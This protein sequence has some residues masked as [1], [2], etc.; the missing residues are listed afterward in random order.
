[1]ELMVVSVEKFKKFRYWGGCSGGFVESS[2]GIG[3]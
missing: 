3:W 1:M 2:G